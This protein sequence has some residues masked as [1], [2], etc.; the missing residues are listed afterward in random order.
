LA[1]AIEITAAQKLPVWLLVLGKGKQRPFQKLA[2]KIGFDSRLL[3]LPLETNALDVYH[4]SDAFILPT[5]YDPCANACLEAS[6]CGLPVIT[7]IGNGAAEL[8][9]GLT[10]ENPSQIQ[11]A[12][13]RCA[14]FARPLENDSVESSR[15]KLD[16]KPCW[17]TIL[18]LVEGAGGR[19]AGTLASTMKHD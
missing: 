9:S 8:V 5:I 3:F 17:D 14:V 19:R 15:S 7:T 13:E 11:D 6:A 2:E 12:A 18:K 10:L 1:W 4:A 16:E